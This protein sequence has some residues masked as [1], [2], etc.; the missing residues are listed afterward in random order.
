MLSNRLV[1]GRFWVR[2][3]LATTQ[4][5][6]NVIGLGSRV[7]IRALELAGTALDTGSS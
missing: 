4:Y 2:K 5:Y 6:R 7:G 1:R 3:D